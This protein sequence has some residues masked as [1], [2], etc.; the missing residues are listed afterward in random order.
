MLCR[1]KLKASQG[2]VGLFVL[3]EK[4]L[5]A[6][7]IKKLAQGRTELATGTSDSNQGSPPPRG[8]GTMQSGT[9]VRPSLGPE[10]AAQCGARGEHPGADRAVHVGL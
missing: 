1:P 6:V 7:E 3:Q 8:S 5:K 9:T 2:A 10:H 4:K